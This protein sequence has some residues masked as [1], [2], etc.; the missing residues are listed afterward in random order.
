[1]NRILTRTAMGLPANPWGR[2]NLATADAGRVDTMVSAAVGADQNDRGQAMVSILAQRGNGK[3]RA[4]QAALNQCR[5]CQCVWVI[6]LDKR[7]VAIS[8]IESALAAELAPK[9]FSLGRSGETRIRRLRQVI[10]EASMRGPIVLVIDDAHE[11]HPNTIRALKRLRELHWMGRSPLLG[12]ILIGQKDMLQ[13]IDEVSLRSD[14]LWMEGLTQ[15]EAYTALSNTVGPAFE[16]QAL[17]ALSGGGANWL[18]L[19]DSADQ[20]LTLAHAQ[21]HRKVTLTDAVQATGQGLKGLAEAVGVSQAEIAR[22]VGKSETQVSRVMSGER[23]NPEVQAKIAD[24]LVGKTG[25]E[26]RSVAGVG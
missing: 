19:I 24:F 14:S 3:T 15:P 1:M 6:R 10:G 8:D 18:D 2:L 5:Q 9:D 17:S 7:K 20:A 22:A 23:E 12:I 13:G 16:P 11:L 25:Q 21:G 4:V 26:K